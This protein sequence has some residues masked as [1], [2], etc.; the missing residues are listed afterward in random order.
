MFPVF[1]NAQ[2]SA[3]VKADWKDTELGPMAALLEAVTII[4]II[5]IKNITY[6]IT[7]RFS[8]NCYTVEP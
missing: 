1:R 3:V 6:S 8:M 5:Y 4:L 2:N 7:L